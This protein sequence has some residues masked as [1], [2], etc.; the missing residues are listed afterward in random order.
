MSLFDSFNE[1]A[2]DSLRIATA[3]VEVVVDVTKAAVKPLAEGAQSV[4]DEVKDLTE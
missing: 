1:L 3:P 4:V 2:E